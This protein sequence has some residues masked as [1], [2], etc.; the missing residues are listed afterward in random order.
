MRAFYSHFLYAMKRPD[1][2]MLQMERA[3]ELDPFNPLLQG[4]HGQALY[5]EALAAANRVYAAMEFSQGQEALASGFAEGGY[6][7]AMRHAA[8]AFAALFDEIHVWPTDIARMYAFAG[9]ESRVLYWLERGF[10]E[11]DPVMP[12]VGVHPLWDLVRDDPRDQDLRRRM[13]LPE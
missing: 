1:E 6:R 12:Y 9:E 10:E 13:V 8:D 4:L 3:V 11:H 5:E 2:A 7:E